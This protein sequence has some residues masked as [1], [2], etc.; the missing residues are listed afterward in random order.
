MVGS[1]NSFPDAQCQRRVYHSH[2]SPTSTKT[3]K[4]HMQKHRWL[5][6]IQAEFLPSWGFQS[7]NKEKHCTSITGVMHVTE[8]K[9]RTGRGAREITESQ[10]S[11]KAS[12]SDAPCQTQRGC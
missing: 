6:R 1:A 10:W 3:N 11:W 5:L 8:L 4:E 12:S 9:V 2:T 7:R